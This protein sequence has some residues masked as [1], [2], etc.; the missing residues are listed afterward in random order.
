MALEKEFDNSVE[1]FAAYWRVE[2]TRIVGKTTM[3]VCV[4]AYREPTAT[5]YVDERCF[6]RVPYAM[7]EKNA[8]TQAYEYVKRLPEFAGAV[9]A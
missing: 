2:E 9:D 4:R 1:K 8:W 7:N 5:Y 6:D 3:M